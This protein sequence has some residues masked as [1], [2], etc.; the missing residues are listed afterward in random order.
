MSDF[1]PKK[2]N[3]FV[4][5][6]QLIINDHPGVTQTFVDRVLTLLNKH[7]GTIAREKIPKCFRSL[8][9]TPRNLMV[10]KV[11]SAT[12][13]ILTFYYFGIEEPLKKYHLFFTSKN[14]LVLAA[15]IDGVSGD[16]STE[17]EHWPI[18]V[19]IM[20]I[21]ENVI[22]P[23]AIFTGYGKPPNLNDFLNEFVEEITKLSAQGM[24]V[25]GTHYNIKLIRVL[26]DAP[27]RCFFLNIILQ[28]SYCSCLY[29]DVKGKWHRNRVHFY[30]PES[31]RKKHKLR[32][33]ERF[34]NLKYK[35][36]QKGAT[37]LMKIP[38]FNC[39]RDCP[40]DIMH[41]LYSGKGI[42]KRIL[43]FWV[44]RDKNAQRAKESKSYKLT[45]GVINAISDHLLSLKNHIP[46]EFQRK[47]ESLWQCNKWKA[48]QSRLFLLYLGIV[49]LR[50]RVNKEIYRNFLLL[51]FSIRRLSD[52]SAGAVERKQ[53][54]QYLLKFI[55]SYANI[56]GKE[57]VNHNCHALEHLVMN[58][59]THGPVD[60]YSAMLFESYLSMF[61]KFK[62]S[63]HLPGQ[64]IVN[65]IIERQVSSRE[66]FYRNKETGPYNENQ[67]CQFP[68]HL[69][70]NLYRTFSNHAINSYVI[71]VK[72]NS[73]N[74]IFLR[75]IEIFRVEN[76]LLENASNN[77]FFYGYK[78]RGRRDVE[79]YPEPSSKVGV[80][81]VIDDI[82]SQ[83]MKKVLSAHEFRAKCVAIPVGSSS[84]LI[85]I[86]MLH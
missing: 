75:T 39:L 57:V 50:K 42:V 86:R 23:A 76:I 48:T 31:I 29:C 37:P 8:M 32:T 51:H 77:V 1:Q 7:K 11:Q 68:V 19:K 22:F 5:G 28:N 45:S 63:A 13:R 38:G 84:K 54:H 83:C 4:S 53:V 49:V 26:G 62:H 72:K 34:N 69:D 12:G 47:A 43:G 58:S 15:H 79:I 71:N 3:T 27:A 64:Q 25:G 46:L 17:L 2:K 59:L 66:L 60:H 6:F 81:E 44:H 35:C 24:V 82:S 14:E 70:R 41:V 55:D 80:Y 21:P 85:A 65:R 67:E 16:K 9:K 33:V 18:L 10:Q 36:L 73:D 20:N 78:L 74:V 40:Y 61:S 56:Y 30:V 52:P